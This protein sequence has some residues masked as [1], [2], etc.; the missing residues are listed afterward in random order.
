M[1]TVIENEHARK[2]WD[3]H[4]FDQREVPLSIVPA[5]FTPHHRDLE[6]PKRQI[7]P[8]WDLP[9]FLSSNLVW[10]LVSEA[11]HV[12]KIETLLLLEELVS[13]SR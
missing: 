5:M 11:S 1:T 4:F 7:T 8:S 12:Q 6:T 13:L 10:G 2:F 9:R 3:T